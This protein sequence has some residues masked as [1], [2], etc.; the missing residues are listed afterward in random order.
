MLYYLSLPWLHKKVSNYLTFHTISQRTVKTPKK[1]PTFQSRYYTRSI[2]QAVGTGNWTH[3]N[4]NLPWRCFPC[5]K[6]A[7]FSL[8]I[9]ISNKTLRSSRKRNKRLRE[10]KKNLKRLKSYMQQTLMLDREKERV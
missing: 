10:Q 4:Q 5:C 9:T 7:G 3:S 1:G 8:R 6:S 2:S